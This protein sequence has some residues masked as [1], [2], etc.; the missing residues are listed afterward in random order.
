M[1]QH[2]AKIAQGNFIGSFQVATIGRAWL[3]AIYPER[4][5]AVGWGHGFLARRSVWCYRLLARAK[6]DC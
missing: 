4:G 6:I 1:L 5:P 3:C 2:I